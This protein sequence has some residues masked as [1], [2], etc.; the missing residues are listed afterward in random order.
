M[1]FY[2]LNSRDELV[3][4]LLLNQLHLSSFHVC[5]TS[6]LELHWFLIKYIFLSAALSIFK[7]SGLRYFVGKCVQAG[8]HQSAELPNTDLLPLWS[9]VKTLLMCL[10][11]PVYKQHFSGE[12][13]VIF[14]FT[15]ANPPTCCFCDIFFFFRVFLNSQILSRRAWFWQKLREAVGC[16]YAVT[17]A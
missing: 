1:S 14:F 12:N 5:S 6:G 9:I 2:S 17:P 8:V 3:S 15:Q 11:R 4:Q 16:Q 10:M 7:S 13:L